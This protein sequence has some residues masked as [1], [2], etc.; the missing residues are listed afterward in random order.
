MPD[1]VAYAYLENMINVQ[2]YTLATDQI[3]MISATLMLSLVTLI[4]WAKPPF[5][6]SRDA[7][8]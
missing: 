2:A 3:L 8:H 4:W 7:A 1:N 5:V 6:A